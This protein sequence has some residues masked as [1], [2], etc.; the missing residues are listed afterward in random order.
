MK[1]KLSTKLFLFSQF[2]ILLIGLSL[3]GALHYLLNIQYQAPTSR[4]STSGGP[5]TTEPRSLL[6]S[7]EEPDDNRLV[8]KSSLLISGRTSPNLPV[9]ISTES[10]DLVINSRSDGAFSSTLELREGVNTITVA[11]FDV[12]GDSRSETKTVY[13]SK[14]KI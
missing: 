7:L 1:R 4:Y 11:V 2:S 10:E 9:L 8:F 6:I 14:E 3:L 5:V 12:S 13:Y